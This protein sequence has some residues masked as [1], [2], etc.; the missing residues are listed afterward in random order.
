MG[1]PTLVCVWSCPNFSAPADRPFRMSTAVFVDP[2]ISTRADGAQ[3]SR[4]PVPLPEDPYETIRQA[5]LDG[6]GTESEPIED[7]VETET[8]KTVRIVVRVPP[9]MSPGLSASMEKVAAISEFAFHKRFRSSY[10]SSLSSSPL[11]LPSRKRYR[12]DEGPTTKDEDL[13]AGDEGLAAGDEGPVIRRGS[14]EEEGGDVPEGQLAGSVPVVGTAV[15]APLGLGYGALRRRELASEEDHV[16]NTFEVGHGSGSSPEPERPERVSTSRQPTLTTW[17]DEKDVWSLEHEQ[18]RVAVTF[19]EIW[20]PVL[21]SD[22]VCR[23]GQTVH[24]RVLCVMPSVIR[25][26]RTES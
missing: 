24:I 5:Y 9:A 1:T 7:P 2:E 20:R 18:E 12:E 17:T 3:S 21:P 10:E 25:K 15:S 6:T 14:R 11:D 8:P 16:Y 23:E 4:V 22:G 19:R 26:E 13:A